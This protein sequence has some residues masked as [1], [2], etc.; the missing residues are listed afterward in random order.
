MKT[1]LAV[2]LLAGRGSRLGLRADEIPKC[3]IE[4]A[5]TTL[6]ERSMKQVQSMGIDNVIL[7][8]GYKADLI[9]SVFGDYWN[10]IKIAYI[11]NENWATTNNV[12]SLDLAIPYI[13]DDFYLLE[14]D[15]ICKNSEILK[16]SKSLNS[17]AIAPFEEYM[18]GTVVSLNETNKV[19]QFYMSDTKPLDNVYKTVNLYNFKQADFHS[20]IVPEIKTL[21]CLDRKQCYYEEAFAKAVE[22]NSI[23]MEGI[24]FN[25]DCWYEIDTEYDLDRA[26]TMFG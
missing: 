14:G 13:L 16:L 11:E 4:I 17:M 23:A 1:D 15:I 19:N 9:R 6:L 5:G 26:K 3:L 21:I 8:V 22:K 24:I 10:G 7:V 20:V 12:V 18:N 25:N 2:Y